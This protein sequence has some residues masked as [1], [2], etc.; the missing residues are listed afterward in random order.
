MT[1]IR[2]P[3]MGSSRSAFGIPGHSTFLLATVIYLLT[4]IMSHHFTSRSFDP[5][6]ELDSPSSTSSS[7]LF[8]FR[9]STPESF[10]FRESTTATR[11]PSV[12]SS[13]QS[14][15]SGSTDDASLNSESACG[16]W[17]TVSDSSSCS[18]VELDCP[19]PTSQFDDQ[20]I[21]LILDRLVS[22]GVCSEDWVLKEKAGEVTV[23][24]GN[25]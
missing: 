5:S 20:C 24:S 4:S 8:S 10:T 13:N 11:S 16:S 9:P 2:Y 7:H 21:A 6:D 23:T 17:E 18:S 22:T 3:L 1:W 15:G 25:E 19:T 12:A 14:K